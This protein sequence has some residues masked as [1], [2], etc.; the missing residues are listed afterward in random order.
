[1]AHQSTTNEQPVKN[2]MEGEKRRIDNARLANLEKARAA[3]QE[4]KRREREKRSDFDVRPVFMHR[5]ENNMPRENI[6]PEEAQLKIASEKECTE[7]IEEEK[8]RDGTGVVQPNWSNVFSSLVLTLLAPVI[9]K[10]TV[11]LVYPRLSALCDD[12]FDYFTSAEHAGENISS[13]SEK[14]E[15]LTEW[16]GQSL[17]TYK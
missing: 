12:A 9:T 1:M 4:K 7:T 10:L 14:Q 13:R 15:N 3:L 2:G 6:L 16:K 11:D 8:K 5:D 17:F